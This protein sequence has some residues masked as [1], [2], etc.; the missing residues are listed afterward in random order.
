MSF[1]AAATAHHAP[2]P[3]YTQQIYHIS[4]LPLTLYSESLSIYLPKIKNFRY[5]V[6]ESPFSSFPPIFSPSKKPRARNG[7]K[8]KELAS[9]SMAFLAKTP[10]SHFIKK[11]KRLVHVNACFSATRYKNSAALAISYLFLL[12]LLF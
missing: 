3:I 5:Y 6:C 8:E 2:T 1:P 7:R 12:T 11:H 9:V 10:R 4:S